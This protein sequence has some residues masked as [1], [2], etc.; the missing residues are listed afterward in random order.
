MPGCG[1]IVFYTESELS[2]PEHAV[3]QVLQYCGAQWVGYA[4][5][6]LE[7]DRGWEAFQ[8]DL[9]RPF[10]AVQ[11]AED[12]VPTEDFSERMSL[13]EAA[14]LYSPSGCTHLLVGRNRIGPNVYKE[15]RR[16]I[17]EAVAGVFAPDD[18]SI[19][20]GWHDIFEMAEHEHG[21]FFGRGFFSFSLFGSGT[22]NDWKGYRRLIFDVPAVQN[23]K[24]HLEAIVGPLKQCAYWDI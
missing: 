1:K 14:A 17:P 18:P 2:E 23:L 3:L 8:E 20:I 12:D 10:V 6:T 19:R 7:P 15:I 13:E 9:E 4:S 16:H 5:R 22:P 21:H 24:S 11:I